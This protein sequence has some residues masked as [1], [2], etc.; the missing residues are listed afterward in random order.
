MMDYEITGSNLNDEMESILSMIGQELSHG[1]GIDCKWEIELIDKSKV[2]ARNSFH[3]M[4]Q[5]GY[6]DGYCDFKLHFKLNDPKYFRVT[7]N[8][9]RTNRWK[10]EKYMLREYLENTLYYDLQTAGVLQ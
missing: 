9:N 8:S 3:C 5:N 2:T 10:A 1:S 4:H 6:Y 7:I